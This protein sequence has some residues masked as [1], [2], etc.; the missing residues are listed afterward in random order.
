[1]SNRCRF[2]PCHSWSQKWGSCLHAVKQVCSFAPVCASYNFV[3][4]LFPI[5][6]S[7]YIFLSP[8]F[9]LSPLGVPAH[10]HVCGDHGTAT[11]FLVVTA[12]LPGIGKWC[13]LSQVTARELVLTKVWATDSSERIAES[14][15]V[16]SCGV[17][18]FFFFCRPQRFCLKFRWTR[19]QNAFFMKE[20]IQLCQ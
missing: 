11:L 15:E 9:F 18:F 20:E 3:G 4:L 14:E 5:F 12:P 10:K 17:F 19:L 8:F 16:N 6:C 13:S 1:M 7:P 2:P